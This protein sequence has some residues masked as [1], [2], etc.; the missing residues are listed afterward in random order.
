MPKKK[1]LAALVAQVDDPQQVLERLGILSLVNEDRGAQTVRLPR[2]HDHVP[3]PGV[4]RNTEASRIR[5]RRKRAHD[6]GDHS[7]C[8]D[9][10]TL[11]EG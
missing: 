8:L 9:T 11:R 1:A 2:I 5:M 10:C 7:M 3:P 6:A 4:R